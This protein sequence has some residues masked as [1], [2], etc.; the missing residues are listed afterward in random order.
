MRVGMARTRTRAGEGMPH[1]NLGSREIRC[2]LVYW[3]PGLSGKTT[4][5]EAVHKKAPPE[6][7]GELVAIATTGERTLFFDY[8]PLDLGEVGGM[9]VRFQLYTVP[10]QRY[11]RS[12]RKLVLQGADGVVFVADSRPE[13]REENLEA[14]ADLEE[15]LAEH[16]L[17]RASVPVV[18]QWN[19][20][21]MPGVLA[22]D[23]L[24]RALNPAGAPSFEAVANR[25]EGVFPTLRCAAGLVLEQLRRQFGFEPA[26]TEASAPARPAPRPVP[27]REPARERERPTPPREQPAPAPRTVAR[28]R[29]ARR[30]RPPVERPAAVVPPAPTVAPTPA[31]VRL[32]SGGRARRWL[33]FALLTAALALLAWRLAPLLG[34]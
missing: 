4:N 16:G 5:L 29:P 31:P 22:V 28:P 21:D 32:R 25:G 26:G 20:R 13:M 6:R 15:T 8:L 30:P 27:V 7:R 24:D 34:L 2:K 11:Y 17:S 3:G 10:G 14:L 12:T 33:G 23:E 18:F 9:R 1:I 19:K